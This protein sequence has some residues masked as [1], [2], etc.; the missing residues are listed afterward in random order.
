MQRPDRRRGIRRVSLLLAALVLCVGLPIW[1]LGAKAASTPT[2]LG[3]AQHGI[4]AYNE[5]WKYQY[6]GK[7]QTVNGVRVSDCSGLIYAYFSDLGLSC[8]GSAGTQVK[9]N[10]I[11]TDD[12]S[13]GIPRIHGLAVSVYNGGDYTHIGIY[14]G[15]GEA[16]D[17]SDVGINMVRAPL[18]NRRWD[19]WHLF[20]NGVK[21]P[22]DGWY[23]FDGKM[24]HY[25]DYEYDVNV[26]VDGYYIGSDGFATLNGA[27]AS[28]NRSILSKTWVPASEVRDRLRAKGY[29]SSDS[30]SDFEYNATVNGSF[31]RLRS[32]PYTSASVV[33][34]LSKGTKLLLGACVEG[35]KA[36]DNGRT[37]TLWY[38]ATTATGQEGYISS[39]LVDMHLKAPTITANREC[40][41]ITSN[42][43]G[44]IYYTTDGSLP[45]GNS[46]PYISPVYNLGCTYKAVVIEG[47]STSPVTTATVLS[48]GVIFTDFTYKDWFA[49]SVDQAVCLKLF[50]GTGNKTF[51]PNT[52]LTRAQFVKVLASIS[53]ENLS[54]YTLDTSKL[55][56][57][58]PANAWYRKQLAWAYS[59]GIIKPAKKFNPNVVLPREQLCTMMDRYMT[60]ILGVEVDISKTKK[61]ADDES[62]SSWA[63]DSVYR[64]RALGIVDGVGG[65]RFSPKGSTQRSAASKVAVLFY[66]KLVLPTLTYSDSEPSEGY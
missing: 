30:P 41:T 5:G 39:L 58:V 16:C 1:Q 14:I 21:Y 10:C 55:F 26:T 61:F 28:V 25:T 27:P 65:N 36:T 6:G 56:T 34:T 23:E 15:N 50:N 47:G 37:S 57:D 48:N 63:T 2:S 31:V 62:I 33:T 12:L 60:N 20:D 53:G 40:V 17:N 38:K 24:V 42:S 29:G 3:L 35:D 51:S 54:G 64:M 11:L 43:S 44:D 59:K 45:T 66:K 52:P 8:M 49:A 32:A 22:R 46:S 19:R 4:N 18:K 9:Y 13:N 7:G